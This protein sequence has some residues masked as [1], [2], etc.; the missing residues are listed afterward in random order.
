MRSFVI[1][2]ILAAVFGIQAA[3]V[4]RAY[5]EV[6]L[7]RGYFLSHPT[8]RAQLTESCRA[9]GERGHPCRLTSPTDISL[10][11]EALRI[12]VTEW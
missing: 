1:A 4:F 6:E 9:S 8:V 12:R 10:L 2:G 7:L 5:R 11:W 3:L